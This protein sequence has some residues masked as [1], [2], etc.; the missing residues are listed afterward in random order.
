[1]FPISSG[2]LQSSANTLSDVD[3]HI[4]VY[5]RDSIIQNSLVSI[6][7]LYVPVYQIQELFSA[8][9]ANT[10]GVKR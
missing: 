5:A 2:L 4:N 3:F 6:F 1:M 8:M 10:Y 7:I 9:P